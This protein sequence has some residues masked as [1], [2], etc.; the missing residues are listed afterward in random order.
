MLDVFKLK[1]INRNS[2]IVHCLSPAPQTHHEN[3]N[4][5]SHRDRQI[6]VRTKRAAKKDPRKKREAYKQTHS[7]QTI[8]KMYTINEHGH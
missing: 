5:A 2:K 4:P 7:T 8:F 1:R 6:L 3:L